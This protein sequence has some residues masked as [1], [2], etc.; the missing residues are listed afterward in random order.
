MGDKER[1]RRK[2][3][4]YW[5]SRRKPDKGNRRERPK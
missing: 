2:K 1:M 4:G 5:E 3:I